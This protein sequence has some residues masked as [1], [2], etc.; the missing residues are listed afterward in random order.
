MKCFIILEF[1]AENPQIKGFIILLFQSSL[2]WGLCCYVCF[3]VSQEETFNMRR[4][5]HRYKVYEWSEVEW[6]RCEKRAAIK[7]TRTWMGVGG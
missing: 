1:K 7:R 2:F 6:V 3:L 4:V 5:S